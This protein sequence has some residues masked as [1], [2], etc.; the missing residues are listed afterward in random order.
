METDFRFN[1]L[2]EQYFQN[3]RKLADIVISGSIIIGLY[4]TVGILYTI[5]DITG[6]PRFLLQYKIQSNNQINY[7]N[8]KLLIKQVLI[9][10]LL[11][12]FLSVAFFQLKYRYCKPIETAPGPVQ[13]VLEIICFMLL[14]EIFFYY[15]HRLL[16]H[17]KIYRHIHKQHHEWQTPIAIAAIYC[18]P[19]EH[20]VSNALPILVGM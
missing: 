4:W 1:R 7:R 18:H 5:V 20:I 19:V 11:S 9:N 8:M 6:R 13:I 16:H 2:L 3:D 14:R 12:I 10:Q 17:P 15:S